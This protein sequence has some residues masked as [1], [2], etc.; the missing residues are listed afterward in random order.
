MNQAYELL[1]KNV[2]RHP[3]KVAISFGEETMTF[4][5]LE[6]RVNRVANAL[7]GLGVRKGDVLAHS[8]PNCPEVVIYT[9]AA[10]RLG[11]IITAVN[12]L[13]KRDEVISVANDSPVDVILACASVADLVEEIRDELPHL[14]HLLRIDAW[15]ELLA[16]GSDDWCPIVECS[17]DDECSRFYTSG[18]TG[19]LRGARHTHESTRAI[20]QAVVVN[21]KLQESDI[22][23]S[24]MPL[25]YMFAN[26]VVLYAPFEVGA[27]IVLVER[28]TSGAECN[29]W[30]TQH[31]V[32]W[33][34]GVPTTLVRMLHEHDPA[35]HRFQLRCVFTAGSKMPPD[36]INQCE[37]VLG[38]PVVEH[39]GLT[40]CPPV[41]SNHPF[42]VR[43]PGKVGYPVGNLYVRLMRPDGSE[44]ADGEAGE[45]LVKGTMVCHEYWNQP[46]ANR[47]TFI[48]GGWMRTGDVA[49]RD[50]DGYYEIV[51]RIKDLI[52]T[53]GTNIYPI[54]VENTL[55]QHPAVGMCA[56]VGIPNTEMGELVRAYIVLKPGH[57][58][59]ESE[60]IEF[61]KARLAHFKAPRS[62]V[63][64]E[65][66]PMTANNKIL[67]RVLR[68]ETDEP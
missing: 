41:F 4:A 14:R 38:C 47:E 31:Q 2:L 34:A 55:Y 10:W 61:A 19:H 7:V 26:C 56:V 50:S 1:R 33:Y 36:L 16:L 13:F 37:E 17:P 22:C 67:K 20:G 9:F 6:R 51:D 8:S 28:F 52:I 49:L 24:P 66:L 23:L 3:D 12:P 30:L 29:D 27:S 15:D 32:T 53:G 21:Q 42:M 35:R 65:E 46:D 62:V 64:R 45:V 11:A 25:F 48:D 59:S 44:A 39:Y 63:F 68:N 60:I 57:S 5:D 58:A 18:T 43:K 40:E 54:E